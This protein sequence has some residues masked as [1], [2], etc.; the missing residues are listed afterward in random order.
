MP[1][2]LRVTCWE[3]VDRVACG[4]ELS[5]D[6]DNNNKAEVAVPAGKEAVAQQ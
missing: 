4:L 3:Q 1:V 6:A 2:K 5:K